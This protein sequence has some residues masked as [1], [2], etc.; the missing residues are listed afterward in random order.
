M[1]QPGLQECTLAELHPPLNKMLDN[2]ISDTDEVQLVYQKF[3]DGI[4]S[5]KI[6][7]RVLAIHLS[8]DSGVA[9]TQ[10]FETVESI[11]LGN[12]FFITPYYQEEFPLSSPFHVQLL[13]AD[14]VTLLGT[15]TFMSDD[16]YYHKFLKTLIELI[17]AIHP[18][19]VV[20]ME[21]DQSSLY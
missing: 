20:P 12:V 1:I 11:P 18:V 6:L 9:G 19:Q 4:L 14:Q 10:P 2:L 7:T 21:R 13:A 15:F 8:Y 3:W 5:A 17:Q 16:S